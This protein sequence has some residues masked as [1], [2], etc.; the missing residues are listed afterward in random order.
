MN[1]VW[2]SKNEEEKNSVQT[3]ING[4][5]TDFNAWCMNFNEWYLDFNEWCV[6]KMADH[7]A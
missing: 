2:M 1:G 7:V 5:H 3:S 6:G 4:E